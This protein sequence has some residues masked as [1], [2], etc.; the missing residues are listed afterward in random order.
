MT[1][2]PQAGRAPLPLNFLLQENVTKEKLKKMKSSSQQC[3]LGPET[4]K[5]WG[6]STNQSCSTVTGKFDFKINLVKPLTGS[7]GIIGARAWCIL[8]FMK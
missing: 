5:I 8:Y 1:E 4:L 6:M 3:L 7:D 2:I